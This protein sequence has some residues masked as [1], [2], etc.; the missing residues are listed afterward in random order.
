MGIVKRKSKTSKQGYLYEVNFTYKDH[1]IT[2]RYFKGGFTTKKAALDHETSKKSEIQK[3]G[4]IK[5]EVKKTF[6]DVYNEFLENGTLQYQQATIHNTTRYYNHFKPLCDIPITHFDYGLLQRFFNSRKNKG[7]ETNKCVKKAINRVLNYAIK[8]GYLRNN[9]LELVT[10][11]GVENHLQHD[12]VLSE[13]DF[14]ILINA[15]YEE[16]TFKHHAYAIAIQI[17]YY[18]GLRISE[19]LALDKSDFDFENNLINVDKK[20]CY[21]GLKKDEFYA[22]H[23]MK[24]KK[25]KSVIPLAQVLKQPLINWFEINHFDKCICDIK[26][27]YMNPN[28]LSSAI[29]K[30]AKPLN[31][32]FHFHMLRHTFATNLVLGE[33]DLKTAQE[34]MRH[35]NINTTISIYTHVETEHKKKIINDIFN[36]NCGESVGT[37]INQKMLN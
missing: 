28:S 3:Y 11:T 18:T 33:V 14:F 9:P 2:K 22:T 30:V 15:L 37:S 20:L 16:K 35:T 21:K 13:N 36:K 6:E 26:G 19:V 34:L 10:V 8:V 24:S 12:Q 29:K 31:I 23:Q 32:D 1:G 4:S 5:K 27:F 7:I 25:S 17:A